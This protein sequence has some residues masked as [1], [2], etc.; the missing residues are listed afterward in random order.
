[1]VKQSFFNAIMREL[2]RELNRYK[3]ALSANYYMHYF[4]S[5]RRQRI[6]NTLKNML[7]CLPLLLAPISCSLY[8]TENTGEHHWSLGAGIGFYSI[9]DYPGSE[10]VNNVFTPIPYLQYQGPRLKLSN[11]R[12]SSLIFNSEK[13]VIDISADGTPPV[14]STNNDIRE[15]MPNLD[16][17]LEMGP[18]IEYYLWKRSGNK[19]FLDIPLR[20]GLAS[21][22]KQVETIGWISNPRIK[23]HFQ[24][25]QWRFRV[26]LGPIYAS[27]EHNNYYYGV[28]KNFSATDRPLFTA[29]KGYSGFLYSAGMQKRQGNLKFDTYIRL[30]DLSNSERSDSPLVKRKASLLWGTS[31]TW[32]FFTQ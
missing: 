27:K 32:I 10:H 5:T 11:G 31:I 22:L 25:Y 21:D 13:L 19:L 29:N 6:S 3:I 9:P 18:A 24:Y 8:A 26:G 4:L 17:V 12:I 30:V 16:A 1:M 2:A 28:K 15:N 23:Y 7:L 14:K 20:Y